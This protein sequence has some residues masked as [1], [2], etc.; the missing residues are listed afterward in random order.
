MTV[1]I[2]PE[3]D[4]DICSDVLD[5]EPEDLPNDVNVALASPPCTCFSLAA[6]RIY[7]DSDGLP[8]DPR[9]SEAVRLVYHTLY[10]IK[11]LDPDYWFLENPRGKLR[12]I[13]PIPPAG[14]VTYC[15]YGYTWQK[16][17][18]LWGDHPG[19]MEYCSCPP[20]G[21]CHQSSGRGFDSGPERSHIRDPAQRA[22]VPYGLSRAILDAVENPEGPKGQTELFQEEAPEDG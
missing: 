1:D 12:A 22:K 6:N 9:V 14:T 15:R 18:D 5:L 11:T 17:T 13:M 3:Y 7:W 21:D 10:L 16:P 19:S 8:K 2:D 4:P 20:G